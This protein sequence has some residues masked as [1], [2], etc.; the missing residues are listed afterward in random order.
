MAEGDA[1]VD[2]GAGEHGA[3]EVARVGREMEVWEDN[4]VVGTGVGTGLGDGI[5]VDGEVGGTTGFSGKMTSA[6]GATI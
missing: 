3:V 5:G 2:R 4:E 1:G 6:V